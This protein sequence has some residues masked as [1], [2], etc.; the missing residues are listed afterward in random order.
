MKIEDAKQ[1]KQELD[2]NISSLINEFQIETGL[3]FTGFDC[4]ELNG[5]ASRQKIVQIQIK[6]EL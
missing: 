4:I 3:T 5:G 1:K 6:V 2:H